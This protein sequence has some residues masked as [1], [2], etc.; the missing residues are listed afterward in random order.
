[1][2]T[3]TIEGICTGNAPIGQGLYG[4]VFSGR[5]ILNTTTDTA[6][7]RTIINSWQFGL[8]VN[9]SDYITGYYHSSGCRVN[10]VINGTTVYSMTNGAVRMGSGTAA[11]THYSNNPVWVASSSTPIYVPHNSDGKKS[12]VVSANWSYPNSSDYIYQIPISQTIA[13]ENI[14]RCAIIDDAPAVTISATGNTNHTTEWTPVQDYYYIIQYLYGSTILHTSS[15]LDKTV[16]SYT[17]AIPPS[18]AA[19]VT[20]AKTMTVKAA[21][22]SYRDVDCTDEVGVNAVDFTV[23]FNS[24]FA[25]TLSDVSLNHTGKLGTSVVAGQSASSVSWTGTFVQ[26]ATQGSAYAVYLEGTSEV[27][28]RVSGSSP[29]T[30]G[31]IPA[32][33]DTSKSYKVRLVVTDSRGFT[34][35]VETSAYTVYGWVAPSI[36]ALSAV[37]CNAD[38]TENA[39]GACYKVSVSYA[40]RS[41]GN[42]NAKNMTVKYRWVGTQNWVE[43]TSGAVADYSADLDLGAYVLNAV[44]DVRL[45]VAVDIWDSYS[46]ESKT[47]VSTII[48]P[49]AMFIYIM[50]DGDI[51][52][53]LGVGM[54]PTEF[55]KVQLGW[56]L[57]VE[58]DEGKT[59]INPDGIIL[60]DANGD[61][62]GQIR[63]DSFGV[64]FG[65]IYGS[66][67]DSASMV[68]LSNTV[69]DDANVD[70]TETENI[71]AVIN[72]SLIRGSTS[73]G[74]GVY[75]WTNN[76]S[77]GSHSVII[78]RIDGGTI[79]AND[80][81]RVTY[82]PG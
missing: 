74:Y 8:Y 76:G 82:I 7:N 48:L 16:D 21:L 72:V 37:R 81:F 51:K 64:K 29:I 47:S 53:A 28:N 73:G 43:S 62:S 75:F 79:S 70:R 24:T 31:V 68:N 38:G 46:A 42:Q 66:D 71:R 52:T 60:K 25:P 45:E 6:N 32:Y 10:V 35:S 9:K 78:K 33:A 3:Y 11:T 17:W 77:L 41:L 12:I 15:P 20:N 67:L 18:I 59:L 39:S 19:N 80:Q 22:H 1:M 4:N 69:R 57:T 65:Y 44:Q 5:L 63:Q 40:I 56:G 13:L 34:A 30:L 50:M 27:G 55:H 54:I 2:A 61:V 36:T 49:G 58:G 26:G 23:T 14:I